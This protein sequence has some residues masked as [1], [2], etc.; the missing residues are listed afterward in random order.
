MAVVL[1]RCRLTGSGLGRFVIAQSTNCLHVHRQ[2]STLHSV[3]FQSLLRINR[4][5]Y[6]VHKVSKMANWQLHARET[7]LDRSSC[8]RSTL[9][10]QRIELLR[11]S[12]AVVVAPSFDNRRNV[13]I[14]F[15]LLAPDCNSRHQHTHTLHTVTFR[16]WMM[17]WKQLDIN[18]NKL[19]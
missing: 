7:P 2:L 4:Q 3:R 5:V 10:L 16:R 12:A 14:T 8:V 13:R 19:K 6:N 9:W 17:K 15:Y 18:D 11:G 1:V